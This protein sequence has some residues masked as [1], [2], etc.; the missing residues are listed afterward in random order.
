MQTLDCLVG[1][2]DALGI[3]VNPSKG[4]AVAAYLFLVT[5]TEQRL[6][7]NQHITHPGRFHGNALD[8]VR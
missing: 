3:L 4:I 8:A 6:G 5:V 1:N 7:R 2:R